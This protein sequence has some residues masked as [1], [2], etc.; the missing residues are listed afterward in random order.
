MS[1][2]CA[3]RAVP[4]L[5]RRTDLYCT[6]D[7]LTTDDPHL[8]VMYHMPGLDAINWSSVSG[9]VQDRLG[10]AVI[11]LA[12]KAISAKNFPARNRSMIRRKTVFPEGTAP[13]HQSVRDRHALE[14]MAISAPS[15]GVL[16]GKPAQMNV[17][18]LCNA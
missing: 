13:A 7:T 15:D 3:R 5:A 16:R 8:L 2:H 17:I 18:D 12:S 11:L 9:A 6:A 10:D 14:K 4:A 1:S